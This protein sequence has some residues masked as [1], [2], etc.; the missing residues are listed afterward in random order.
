M[1]ERREENRTQNPEEGLI[2]IVE[3]LKEYL[4]TLGRM[5]LWV[6]ILTLVGGGISYARSYVSWQPSYTASATFTI[7]ASQD[8]STG[9]Y[10][11][12]DNATAEQM[13]NTFPYI[14]T[15]GVLS[16]RAAAQMGQEYVSGQIRAS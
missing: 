3:L 14:L 2:D 8:T 15:S 7:T 10:S 11:C 5:W 4:R 6:L 9:S 16:R 1:S 13:V 12:Y